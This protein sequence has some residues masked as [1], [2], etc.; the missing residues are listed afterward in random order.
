MSFTQPVAVLFPSPIS[1]T[2]LCWNT[3]WPLAIE[4]ATG[5]GSKVSK[6]TSLSHPELAIYT[7]IHWS[8]V[9]VINC[10]IQPCTKNTNGNANE[11]TIIVLGKV[12]QRHSNQV[13]KTVH[14]TSGDICDQS[15][16]HSPFFNYQLIL[17]L[18]F[19]RHTSAKVPFPPPWPPWLHPAWPP[20]A[21]RWCQEHMHHGVAEN[22]SSELF[23]YMD[24]WAG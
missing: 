9:P 4:I 10:M 21:N 8:L 13:L 5:V 6:S 23:I 11:E 7:H 24:Y 20:P 14:S 2:S 1:E 3:Y 17:P 22:S 19:Y 16:D 12:K 18:S 15:S